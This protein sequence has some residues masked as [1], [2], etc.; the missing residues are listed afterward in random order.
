ML[1]MT[2]YLS[3]FDLRS[4]VGHDV[5]LIS[6]MSLVLFLLNISWS[7]IARSFFPKHKTNKPEE[8][9]A[10]PI[11]SQSYLRSGSKSLGISHSL[12]IFSQF[13]PHDQDETH[14]EHLVE[15]YSSPLYAS[16][17]DGCL[18]ETLRKMKELSRKLNNNLADLAVRGINAMIIFV[19]QNE[20]DDHSSTE[21]LV[22]GGDDILTE[23]LV[24]WRD[25]Q[26]THC[27]TQINLTNL[28]R[29]IRLTA[30]LNEE[31]LK[32]NRQLI[33]AFSQTIKSTKQTGSSSKEQN[34]QRM[35][36]QA[37]F[38]RAREVESNLNRCRSDLRMYSSHVQFTKVGFFF[39]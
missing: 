7:I 14:Y 18:I 36:L 10:A 28:L 15:V 37:G 34:R 24:N 26:S 30:L 20:E 1:C 5:L 3:K 11:I 35:G 23:T 33:D 19:F 27:C 13:D 16:V 6:S 39:L 9:T 22:N 32:Q 2:M 12:M 8:L 29:L 21:A 4:H 25:D 38:A 17:I 31:L